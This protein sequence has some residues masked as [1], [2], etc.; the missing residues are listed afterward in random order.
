M[1]ISLQTK[2]ATTCSLAAG[3]VCAFL[4]PYQWVTGLALGALF[5]HLKGRSLAQNAIDGFCNSSSDTFSFSAEEKMRKK[6]A[7][8][9]GKASLPGLMTTAANVGACLLLIS[10]VALPLIF[11]YIPVIGAGLL[12]GYTVAAYLNLEKA[13]ERQKIPLIR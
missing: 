12:I 10:K 4:S 11:N 7:K 2:L 6:A 13:Q 5:G 9:L 1:E 8:Q 3:A